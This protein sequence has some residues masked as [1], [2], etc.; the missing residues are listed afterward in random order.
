MAKANDSP[1]AGKLAEIETQIEEH[2]A[3]VTKA[4]EA[5]RKDPNNPELRAAVQQAKQPLMALS[6]ERAFYARAISEA[7]G[8][9]SYMPPA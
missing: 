5:F 9:T 2:E 3:A 8:G 6:V 7:Q 1:F 4:Q